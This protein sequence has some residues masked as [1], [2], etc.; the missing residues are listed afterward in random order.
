MATGTCKCSDKTK[1]TGLPQCTEEF[2]QMRNIIAVQ[3]RDDAGVENFLD[4]SVTVDNTVISGLINNTDAS[5]R[6]FPIRDFD[7]VEIL[8][9]DDVN[10]SLA[11]GVE[12]FVHEG[13]RTVQGILLGAT[14]QYLGC[15]Q[16]FFCKELSYYIVDINGNLIGKEKS[17]DP[18]KLFPIAIS[19]GTWR[20]K[21]DF[22]T[23]DAA[24]DVM[25]NFTHDI[26]END[27][28]LNFI[29]A[30]STEVDWLS[31]RGLIDVF[32][33]VVAGSISTTGFT[34]KLTN[35][36][37][38]ALTDQPHKGLLVGD[39]TLFNDTTVLAVVVTSLTENPNGTYVWA[40]AV[41]APSD[42]LDPAASKV[43][44][45]YTDLDDKTVTL[46]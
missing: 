39:V 38:D 17:T 31:V 29:P 24:Q 10:Q 25:L 45:D 11:S 40:F 46:P 41:Q 37:G 21:F 14:P 8:R 26:K 20:P 18:N 44:F 16:S 34:T 1:N 23:D 2:R 15:L 27:A 6:W 42:V 9:G 28:D 5:K 35:K 30:K 3:T 32:C 19:K 33:E 13:Q 7:N 4:L 43:G 12:R 36:F 22:P